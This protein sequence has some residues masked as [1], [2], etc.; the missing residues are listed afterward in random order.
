M[1]YALDALGRTASRTEGEETTTF[2][3]AGEGREPARVVVAPSGEPQE[4]TLVSNSPSGPLAQGRSIAPLILRSM[5][6]G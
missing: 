2:A 1:S 6:G 3:Y 5:G 4:E